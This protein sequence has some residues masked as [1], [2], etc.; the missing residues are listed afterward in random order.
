MIGGAG[1]AL[2]EIQQ[3]REKGY[4]GLRYWALTADV[5]QALGFLVTHS[6]GSLAE[7]CRFAGTTGA[8]AR[9]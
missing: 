2:A 5:Q 6:A 9:V 7:P 3:P 1:R 4:L 8:A